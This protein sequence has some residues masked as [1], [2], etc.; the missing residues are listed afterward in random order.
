MYHQDRSRQIDRD[1]GIEGVHRCRPR[2]RTDDL[3]ES[4]RTEHKTIYRRY[5]IQDRRRIYLRDM[6]HTSRFV[7]TNGSFYD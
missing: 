3:S 6:I 4:Q 5:E 2:Q 1:R 7:P